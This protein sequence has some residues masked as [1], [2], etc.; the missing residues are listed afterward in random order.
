M[1][2][3]AWRIVRKPKSGGLQSDAEVIDQFAARHM[4]LRL[5][6]EYL[7][8]N[9]G[10]PSMQHTLITAPSGAG[11]TMLLAR[12]AA[13]IRTNHEFSEKLLPVRFT[14]DGHGIFSLADFWMEALLQLAAEVGRRDPAMA[15]ALQESH[16][17]LSAG[18]RGDDLE[19]RAECAVLN[20]ADELD[21]Q[22]VLMVENL[23]SIQWGKGDLFG[24]KL[25]Q[26]LQTQPRIIM[27][28]TADRWIMEFHDYDKPFYGFF[29]D[30]SLKPL[31]VED[32]RLLWQSASADKLDGLA[33]RPLQ[34]LAGGSPRLL[35]GMAR[36][37]VRPPLR[38]LPG[39]LAALMDCQADSFRAQLTALPRTER[40]VYLA[41]IEPWE[42]PTA[43]EIAAR[44]RMDERTVSALLTRLVK[45]GA[46]T[47]EADGPRR[48]AAQRMF[49]LPGRMRHE[50]GRAVAAGLV[51]FM[52]ALYA[53]SP[54]SADS[55]AGR[56][57]GRC[58]SCHGGGAH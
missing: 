29:R 14:E 3:S 15:Q 45:R 36:H 49:S 12:M 53:P 51:R 31:S 13:E 57:V 23:Q 47:V 7:R 1:S 9:I 26:V 16:R 40:R 42:P 19:V 21:R 34:I 4:D 41:A 54:A 18:W 48:Y 27:M 46:L 52:A 24:W 11:K 33:V 25:R 43:A 5:L 37:S 32:S 55:P 30:F 2:E 50:Q 44:A 6:L 35:A 17:E 10:Q 20:A 56:R 8:G 22:L 28:A 39:R 58:P 38:D